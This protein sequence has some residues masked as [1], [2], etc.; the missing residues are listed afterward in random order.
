MF[1]ENAK[2]LMKEEGGEVHITHKTNWFHSQWDLEGLASGAGL[3]LIGE[4]MKFSFIEYPGYN[5]KYG[6]GGD[7]NFNCNPS[8]T[9][10]FGAS[11]QKYR[12]NI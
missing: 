2:K 11:S 1:M 6:F 4:P 8:S 7:K 3:K 10:I 12:Q 9:F 5:T